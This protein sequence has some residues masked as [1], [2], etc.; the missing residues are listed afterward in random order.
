MDASTGS[1]GEPHLVRPRSYPSQR[2]SLTS[3]L[4]RFIC[5]SNNNISRITKMVKSFCF[6]SSPPPS[7]LSTP[8]VATILRSLG[9]GYRADFIQ[10]TAKMLVDA[11][12]VCS[13]SAKGKEGPEKW[14]DSL[15]SAHTADAREELLKLMGVCRK[16][17]GCILLMSLDKVGKCKR[18]TPLPIVL[19]AWA[20]RGHP[21]RHARSP[22]CNKALRVPWCVW[23]QVGNVSQ[24]V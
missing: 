22:D 23:D 16:V 15:C 13:S 8:D 24:V 14:L 2:S 12:G 19:T 6:R 10:K 9:F 20:G 1:T 4:F 11:H 18:R 21:C 17:A 7:R 3:S 5:S